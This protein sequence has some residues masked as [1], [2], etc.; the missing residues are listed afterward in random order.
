MDAGTVSSF[1]AGPMADF[2]QGK[3]GEE[4]EELTEEWIDLLWDGSGLATTSYGT[5]SGEHFLPL[6]RFGWGDGFYPV[7]KTVDARVLCSDSTSTSR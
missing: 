4:I 6:I 2:L 1:D 7:L 3:T 5:E